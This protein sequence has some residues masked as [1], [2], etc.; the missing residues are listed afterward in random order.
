MNK[1]K[2]RAAIYATA[3]VY[4]L[5]LAYQ[6]FGSRLDDGGSEYTLML[7]F[8]IFFLIAGLGLIAFS[9]HVVRKMLD[10][11]DDETTENVENE[12]IDQNN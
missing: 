5:Y 2:S 3:G 9:I 7:I 8:S 4:L 11:V 12:E 1:D 6:I 10:S